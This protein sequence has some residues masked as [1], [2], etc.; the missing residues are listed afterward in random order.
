MKLIVITS[1]DIVPGEASFIC[2]LL[3]A[4][5][6]RVHLRKP[7]GQ[8]DDYES[9]IMQIPEIYRKRLVVHDYFELCSKYML[10]GIHLNVRNNRFSPNSCGTVSCSCHSFT[11]VTERKPM[12]DYMFLSPIFDSISKVG[13]MSAFSEEILYQASS[14]GII[15]SKIMALGGVTFQSISLLEKLSFG[16]AVM[17]GEVWQRI[18]DGDINGVCSDIKEM[19]KI[20]SL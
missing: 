10:G 9:I 6:D 5:T 7:Y 19:K 3:D 15:D 8:R 14:D 17:L 4:G 18:A 2:R 11:D 16:G 12:M 13:Y 20:T 1:P